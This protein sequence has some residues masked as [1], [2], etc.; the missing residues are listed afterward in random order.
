MSVHNLMLRK[1]ARTGQEN[2]N[3]PSHANHRRTHHHSNVDDCAR[4]LFVGFRNEC[5][6][7]SGEYVPSR[8]EGG[9]NVHFIHNNSHQEPVPKTFVI[10]L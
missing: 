6:L 1:L 10:V 4:A 2:E 3:S 7:H 8:R 5:T 9:T